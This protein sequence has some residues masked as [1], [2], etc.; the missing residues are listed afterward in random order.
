MVCFFYQG[1]FAKAAAQFRKLTL[2]TDLEQYDCRPM[3]IMIKWRGQ[4]KII[5]APRHALT[6]G[7]MSM[8]DAAQNASSAAMEARL[9]DLFA[10]ASSQ[11]AAAG[12]TAGDDP[13]LWRM[14]AVHRAKN[15]AQVSASLGHLAADPKR[16]W[17]S[18]EAWEPARALA[19]IYDELGKDCVSPTPVPGLSLLL[20]MAAGLT[21]IF[22][23]ARKIVTHVSGPEFLVAA[24]VRRALLL[25]CSELVINALKYAFPGGRSGRILIIVRPHASG[26]D[27]IVEDDGVGIAASSIAG[28]G[29]SLI[30]RLA[31]ISGTSVTR[32][33]GRGSTGLRVTIRAFL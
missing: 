16:G 11:S 10:P 20:S 4:H 22:G 8:T 29:G 33:A 18:Q 7:A 19:R 31:L 14:D 6:V 30:N 17:V 25:M 26:L 12:A 5:T 27:I 2:R 3:L 1:L 21:D 32:T 9:L 28:Q 13:S 23:S 24:E 15:L